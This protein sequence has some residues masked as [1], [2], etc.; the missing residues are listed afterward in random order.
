MEAGFTPIVD[1]VVLQLQLARYSE[2]LSRW[3]IRLVV[4]APPVNIALERDRGRPEK[5]VADRFA[6][7]DAELHRQMHGLGLWLDTSGMSVAETVEVIIRCADEAT[8]NP[9]A[10]MISGLRRSNGEAARRPFQPMPPRAYHRGT[11]RGRQ[12]LQVTMLAF[13]SK[14][15]AI[16]RGRS[17]V[18]QPPGRRRLV[19]P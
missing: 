6:Y 13:V 11:M 12:E 7:L 14:A 16:V 9:L 18:G 8:L 4:L 5:H 2:V 17:C 15:V 10:L 1:D 19:V 3:P